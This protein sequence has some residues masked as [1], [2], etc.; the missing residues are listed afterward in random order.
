[1]RRSTTE[2]RRTHREAD[3]F[4]LALAKNYPQGGRVIS[5]LCVFLS[6]A[7][8]IEAGTQAVASASIERPSVTQKKLGD[9]RMAPHAWRVLEAVIGGSI[10]AVRLALADGAQIDARGPDG[11]TG[12]MHA[13]AHGSV[14]LVQ[15]L[16]SKGANLT[17]SDSG[18]R[19]P[20]MYAAYSGHY[21]TADIL[22]AAGADPNAVDALGMTPLMYAARAGNERTLKSLLAAGA[23]KA[24][25]DHEG[26]RAL[27][28]AGS[29]LSSGTAVG[30]FHYQ[31]TS[32]RQVPESIQRL[33]Q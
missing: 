15:L 32:K 1:L 26:H 31:L 29:R 18:G 12:L 14:E 8:L 11:R 27:D 17:A 13:A 6:V 28:H 30:G 25:C 19:T 22:L 7:C 3:E 23:D 20:I 24:V 5:S 4:R 33:L 2:P 21:E 16:L 10:E 9:G